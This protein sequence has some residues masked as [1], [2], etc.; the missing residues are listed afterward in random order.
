MRTADFLAAFLSQFLAC[1]VIAAS[2]SLSPNQCSD[3]GFA[4]N[5]LMCSSCND[6]KQ[7]KLGELEG[8]CRQCCTHD[9]ADQDEG[10]GKTKYH[11]AVLQVCDRPARFP[12]FSVQYVRGA[13]PILN[14]F[15]DRDEQVES[16]GIEKWD[17]DTLTAF[18]EENLSH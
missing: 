9:D 2:D 16:M 6:L 17:T 3:I 1:I 10:E 11:R 14:L 7:F 8:S 4:S 15:N 13:D 5:N 12:S 18:L